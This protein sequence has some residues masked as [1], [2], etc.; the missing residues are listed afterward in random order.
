MKN[1]SLNKVKRTNKIPEY[2]IISKDFNDIHYCDSFSILTQTNK[3]LDKITTE[4]FQTPHWADILMKVRNTVA[5]FVGLDTGGL[6]KDSHISDF[7]PVGSRAVYFTVIDR[8]ENEIIMAENDKHINFRISIMINR[9]GNNVT[10]FLTTLLKFNNFLGQLYF[11]PVK[12]F[13]RLIVLS[14]LKGASIRLKENSLETRLN[15][16]I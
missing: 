4:V 5:K 1:L 12:P 14:L 10:I 9:E 15:Q 16:K 11:F 6:K 7:Y 13:H 3:N 2:S 8:N